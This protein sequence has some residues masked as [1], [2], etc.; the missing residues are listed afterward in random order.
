MLVVW[1][2][3]ILTVLLVHL[4]HHCNHHYNYKGMTLSMIL[5][6]V[7]HLNAGHSIYVYDNEQCPRVTTLSTNWFT[8]LGTFVYHQEDILNLLHPEKEVNISSLCQSQH[9]WYA[10]ICAKFYVD[11]EKY[12]CRTLL[13]GRISEN[14]FFVGPSVLNI[15]CEFLVSWC[16]NL[17]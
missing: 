10:N 1:M 11:F 3:V 4:H 14:P 8:Y 6:L 17:S 2:T 16:M 9:F 7:F 13:G 12:F 15:L 5:P